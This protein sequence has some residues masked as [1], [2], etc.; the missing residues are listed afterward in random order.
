[1]TT[2]EALMFVHLATVL[3][4]VVLGALQFILKKGGPIHR[5]IGWV[6]M[7]F[8]MITAILTLFMKA[9]VGS[10]L[11]NH[12]GWIHLFSILTIW[13]V[14]TAIIAVRKGNIKSHKRKMILLYVGA[15]VIAGAFTLMPGRYLHS[16]LF[17]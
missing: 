7:I 16:V 13:T 2:Y 8:M 11:F 14:P 9:K 4:A 6:Y 15:I 12:F 3:P 10:T 5:K 17:N 1:M